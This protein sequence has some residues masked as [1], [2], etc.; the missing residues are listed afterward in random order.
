MQKTKILRIRR[1][2]NIR[3]QRVFI[4]T[5]IDIKMLIKLNILIW[6]V[7]LL[8]LAL[9]ALF[10]RFIIYPILAFRSLSFQILRCLL[11]IERHHYFWWIISLLRCIKFKHLLIA[12]NIRPWC[13][14]LLMSRLFI[15]LSFIR[16]LFFLMLW[17]HQLQ[18][19]RL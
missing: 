5:L 3:L 9:V 6:N 12:A 19:L 10:I 8:S 1:T 14:L 7:P 4:S 13:P 11:L 15:R 16:K 18:D 2:Y 17:D